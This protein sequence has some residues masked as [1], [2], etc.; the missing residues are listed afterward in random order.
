[1]LHERFDRERDDNVSVTAVHEGE[2]AAES[3]GKS[4]SHAYQKRRIRRQYAAA[5]AGRD[6]G[7]AYAQAARQAVSSGIGKARKG[8]RK[9]LGSGRV[10]AAVLCLI[11]MLAVLLVTLSSCV[12]LVQTVLE[13]MIFGTYPAEEEDILAAE[14]AYKQMEDDLQSRLDHYLEDH[15]QYDEAIIDQMELWHD[16]YVLIAFVSAYIGDVWTIDDV[17][18]VLERLFEQQ[19]EVRTDTQTETRYRTETQTGYEKVVDPVSGA[20]SWIPYTYEAQVP[21]PY[22]IVTVKVKNKI[23]SHLPC[24]M[25]SHEKLGMYAVYMATLGNAPELFAGKPH[26]S[27]LKDPLE[28]DVPEEY[29]EADPQF[30]KLI[31]EAERYLGYPYV[32]GGD[33]PS[34]S[35]DCS[36]FVSW[37][38]NATGVANVGRLGATGLYNACRT[39][40]EE[41][42]RPGDLIFFSGTLGE[43]VDGNEGITHV[44]LYVGDGM[45]IHCG[46][47]ISYADLS[48]TYW[49]EHFHG[50]GRLY[51]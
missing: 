1:M 15:P 31:E 34:T 42:A 21:Y 8:A 11:L 7:G 49:Q 43:G 41:E 26:A 45:M 50:Y 19:Y 22:R 46:S 16:P 30:A 4:A 47:P 12:P 44:G 29:K 23:L 25:L 6:R 37:I 20:V 17:Y 27:Q 51:E 36:G 3:L 18:P 48:R 35:F 39:I 40:T 10:K 2:K 9:W 5:I 38:F 28:H 14:R 32:W 24:V 13:A 33:D